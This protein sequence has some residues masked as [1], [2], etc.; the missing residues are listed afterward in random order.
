MASLKVTHISGSLIDLL[1]IGDSLTEAVQV[2]VVTDVVF[3]Y[4]DEELVTLQVAKPLNPSGAGL[5]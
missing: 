1:E 2:E 5:A 3:V 4:L